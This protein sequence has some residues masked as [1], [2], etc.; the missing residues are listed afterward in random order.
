MTSGWE[1]RKERLPLKLWAPFDVQIPSSV[2][3]LGKSQRLLY[4]L[5]VNI[6]LN[7]SK[8]SCTVSVAFL[9]LAWAG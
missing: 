1:G 2:R 6:P 7:S 3:E 5:P 8:T 4:P 9:V